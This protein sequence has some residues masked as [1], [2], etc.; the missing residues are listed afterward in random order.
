MIL[1]LFFH[2]S[3]NI[4]RLSNAVQSVSTIR[5]YHSKPLYT[6]HTV[7]LRTESR[8][9][10]S[11][12]DEWSML[13]W[14]S[15]ARFPNVFRFVSSPC[16]LPQCVVWMI[17]SSTWRSTRDVIYA[18]GEGQFSPMSSSLRSNH[19]T[20]PRQ[21]NPFI[22]MKWGGIMYCECEML[23]PVLTCFMRKK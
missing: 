11:L 2:L 13:L 18:K 7:V 1:E 3:K 9:G 12:W 15:T 21:V 8:T 14:K 6:R 10:L 20:D 4:K 17:S 22:V 5:N 23:N 16:V 19:F